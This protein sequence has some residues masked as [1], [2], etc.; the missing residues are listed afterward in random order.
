MKA[1]TNEMIARMFVFGGAT[2]GRKRVRSR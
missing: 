2:G 1:A